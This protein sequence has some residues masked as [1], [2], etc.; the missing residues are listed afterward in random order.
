M[1][2]ESLRGLI[3][4]R[5]H[6]IP[7]YISMPP[8]DTDVAGSCRLHAGLMPNLKQGN[9]GFAAVRLT[10]CHCMPFT[11][12]ACIEGPSSDTK[13]RR[14]GVGSRPYWSAFLVREG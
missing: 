4:T 12:K 8:P 10:G 6:W 3:D 9:E 7:G 2:V 5:H 14:V 13:E 11:R 1:G